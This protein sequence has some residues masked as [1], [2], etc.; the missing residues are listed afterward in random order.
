MLTRRKARDSILHAKRRLES[1]NFASMAALL[2]L[3]LPTILPAQQVAIGEYVVPTNSS[4]EGDGLQGITAGPDGALWF[5]E[6]A[7]NAMGRITTAGVVTKYP[8]PIA[9]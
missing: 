3:T 4:V 8:L 6:S 7:G 9:T 2:L 5:T 1:T